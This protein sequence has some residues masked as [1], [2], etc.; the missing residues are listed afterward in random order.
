MAKTM[1]QRERLFPQVQK[2]LYQIAWTAARRHPYPS[3]EESFEEMKSLAHLA[4][5]E[6]CTTFDARRASFVTHCYTKCWYK[7]KSAEME[8]ALRAFSLPVIPLDASLLDDDEEGQHAKI[9]A[10]TSQFNLS[11][12]M[13]DLSDDARTIVHMLVETPGELWDHC[14]TS[15]HL[16]REVKWHFTHKWRNEE[17]VCK[18]MNEIRLHVLWTFR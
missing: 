15:R 10:V 9:P 12:F 18:A 8:S 5:V 11:E 2:M 4:F 16:I 14:H 7:L 3:L 13:H 1:T 6:A 17:R